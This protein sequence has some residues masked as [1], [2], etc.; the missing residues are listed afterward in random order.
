M[1]N[2][3]CRGS[4]VDVLSTRTGGTIGIDPDIIVCDLN[5]Y[6]VLYIR[7]Y[8]AGNKGSLTFSCR[9]KRRNAYQP[10]HS[11]FGFQIAVCV[12]S[13]DLEGDRLNSGFISI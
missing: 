1:C 11:F 7:H 4:L 2:T 6:V 12:F 9:I 13:T 3:D 5:V 10:V 8:I